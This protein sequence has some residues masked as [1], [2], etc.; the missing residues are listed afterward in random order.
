MV[1]FINY[2]RFSSG[3]YYADNSKE[4]LCVGWEEAMPIFSAN[5]ER[6]LD[7]QFN[8]FYCSFLLALLIL[9]QT[10]DTVPDNVPIA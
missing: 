9:A 1:N 5:L 3:L 4:N 2:K 8:I 6:I 7:N 10:K